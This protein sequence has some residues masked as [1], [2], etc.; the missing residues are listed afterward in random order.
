MAMARFS[1]VGNLREK[2]GHFLVQEAMVE[3]VEH[4]PAH[5]VFQLLQVDDKSRL[6]IDRALHR[7]FQRVV[8]PV[9]F[10]LLHLPKMRW[11]SSGVNAG[12]W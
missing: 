12:L 8:V 11:F 3:R 1:V 10:G 4:F 6:R 2:L 5:D 7:D 9:P